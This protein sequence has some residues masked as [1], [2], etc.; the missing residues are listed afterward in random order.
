MGHFSS[1]DWLSINGTE[2]LYNYQPRHLRVFLA[3]VT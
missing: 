3:V 1:V 2:V